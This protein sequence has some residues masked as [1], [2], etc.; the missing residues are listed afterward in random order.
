MKQLDDQLPGGHVAGSLSEYT[1]LAS[2]A[3]GRGQLER[4]ISPYILLPQVKVR[5][6]TV[7]WFS[8]KAY[9]LTDVL[10]S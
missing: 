4:G 8:K 3:N 10:S 1:R 5:R 9:A 6:R 7:S 2:W